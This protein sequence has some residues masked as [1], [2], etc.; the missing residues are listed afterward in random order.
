[1]VRPL[2]LLSTLPAWVKFPPRVSLRIITP[3]DDTAGRWTR[4]SARMRFLSFDPFSEPVGHDD[5]KAVVEVFKN[6]DILE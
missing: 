2:L 1:V 5:R 6:A 3:D 4:S